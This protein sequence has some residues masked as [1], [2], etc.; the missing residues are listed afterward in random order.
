MHQEFTISKGWKTS[1][2]LFVFGAFI[3]AV[4]L[5]YIAG[6]SKNLWLCICG[7][8]FALLFAVYYFLYLK[9]AQTIISNYGIAQ[10][11][12]TGKKKEIAIADIAGYKIEQSRIYLKNKAGKNLL[13]I[14]DYTYLGNKEALIAWIVGNFKDLDQQEFNDDLQEILDDP[15]VGVSEND[16]MDNLK[17]AKTICSWLNNISF[18]LAFWLFLY[19][20]PYDLAVLIALLYPLVTMVVQYRFRKVTIY[21]DGEKNS[22]YPS[23]STALLMPTMGLMLRAIVDF[24]LLKWPDC[25]MTI[26]MIAV[27]LSVIFAV[28]WKNMLSSSKKSSKGLGTIMLFVLA[29]SYSSFMM[30]NCN[31]DYSKSTL[32][33]AKVISR[34]VTHGKHDAYYLTLNPWGPRTKAEEITVSKSLYNTVNVGDTVQVYVKKGTLK[35]PWFFVSN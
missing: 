31:F 24:D 15:E 17:Q 12:A 23:L 7:G 4:Y 9:N 14:P 22:A 8:S 32:Y 3:G 11:T 30:V 5:F 26:G 20:H 28:I 10:V 6:H 13:T 18:A 35:V 25:L 34:E 29:Y 33:P 1:I 27:V 21:S 16:R 19:P 2:Y